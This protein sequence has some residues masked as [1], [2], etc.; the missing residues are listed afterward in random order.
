Q[1]RAGSKF[2]GGGVASFSSSNADR[3]ERLRKLALETIDLDNDP[4]FFKNNVGSKT[5][6]QDFCDAA[7]SDGREAKA[8]ALINRILSAPLRASLAH[9]S[10]GVPSAASLIPLV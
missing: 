2:G 7:N 9:V 8:Q 1:N 6:V 5:Q 10:S 3:H 4:Y